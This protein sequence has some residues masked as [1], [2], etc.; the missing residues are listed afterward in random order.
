M[1]TNFVVQTNEFEGPLDTLLSLIEKR[2]LF[3]NDISLAKVTGDYIAFINDHEESIENKSEFVAIASTL[4]LAK[5]KSLLPDQ[6]TDAEQDEINELEDRL[7]AYRIMK[8]RKEILQ[9]AFGETVLF[10]PL[11]KKRK[12][13]DLDFA[14]G[15]NLTSEL[16]AKQ[17]KMAVVSLPEE[18]LPTASVE[19]KVSLKAEIG[20]LKE[21]C[22]QLGKVRFSETVRSQSRPDHVVLFVAIL[23]LI[24]IGSLEADQD[25]HFSEITITHK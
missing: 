25:A 14:P 22:Q 15:D 4:V 3:I 7:K 19:S 10:L 8:E 24:K 5:S 21:R 23:E 1:Q 18:S 11:T 12:A 16:L 9:D 13:A 20:R 6:T 2:K 17:A